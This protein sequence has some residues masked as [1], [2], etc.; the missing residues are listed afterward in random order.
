MYKNYTSLGASR[1]T[2]LKKQ[3][4][5]DVGTTSEANEK[6]KNSFSFLM[7]FVFAFIILVGLNANAQVSSY[8]FAQTTGTFTTLTGAVSGGGA[9]LATATSSAGGAAGLDD[10]IYSVTGFP[11]SYT[12]NGTAYTGCS[13]S[14]NG[15]ITFGGT[16]PGTTLYA[17]ITGA[18]AYNGAISAWGKDSDSFSAIGGRTGEIRWDVV[19]TSPNREIVIQWKDFRP[20]F[21][22]STT[23]VYGFSYQIRLQENG[24][25]AVIAYGP[26]S[27]A[28]GTTAVSGSTT[29]G[30]QV[31]LRGTSATDFNNRTNAATVLFTASTAGATNTTSI[32]QAFNTS[33]ATPGMPSNG[34]IYTYSPPTLC[35]GTP[36][37]GTIPATAGA[38]IGASTTLAVSGFTT[39]VTGITFQWL[40]SSDNIT[41]TNVVGG[42]GATTATY[43]TAAISATKYYQCKV[44]C[45]NG[46]GNATTNS[47]TVNAVNC[48]FDV[49]KTANTY[50]SISGTGTSLTGTWRN[51]VNTDDNLSASQPI[52]FAF[53]YKGNSYSTFSA[54]TNGFLTF[55]TGTAATGSGTGAYGYQNTAFTTSGGTG[56]ILTIAPFYEDLVAPG[57]PGTAAG[58]NAAIKYQLTGTAPNRVATIEWIG[59]ETFGN[60]GPNLNFQVKLYETTGAVEI[61]YGTMELFNGTFNFSYT[62][63][64][65]INGA[66]MGATPTVAE[67][68]TQQVANVQN[69]SNLAANALTGLQ[70]CNVKYVFT[71][72][73]YSGAASTPTITNDESAGAIALT[74]NSSPC[75]ALCGTYYR[76]AGAT[77]SAGIGVCTATTAGTPDD[78]VWFKFDATA[79]NTTIT[80]R[81]A[82][83]YDV[84][85]QLLD[86][87]L[88]PIS[89]ANGTLT[90]LTESLNPT[91]L[92]IGA[93]YYVRV[94]HSGAGNGTTPEISICVNGFTPPPAN[95]DVCGAINLTSAGTCTATSGS[96]LNSTP[97]VQAVCA[98]TADDDVWYKFTAL[99]SA[100][101]VTVQSGAGFNAHVQ[102]F[103]SSDNL[104]SGTLTSLACVNVTSTA[105]VETYT[106]SG[107]TAGN[108]YFVRVYH[109]ASGTGTGAFTICVTASTPAC[110]A[111]PTAP[112]NAGTACSGTSV[113]LSWP[114]ASGATS[115]DLVIDGGSVINQ[116]ALTYDAG[117]L[118]LGAHTWSVTPRNIV[119]TPSGCASWTF[120][121]LAAPVA[122]TASGPAT[123]FTA[124]AGSYSETG[125]GGTFQ[126]KSATVSGGPY[127]NIT[128]A[129]TNPASISFATPGTYYVVLVRTVSGCTV[130]TST[131]VTT[132]V[133]VRGDSPCAPIALVVGSNG[134]YS[135]AGATGDVGEVVPPLT[136]CNVQ[137]GWCPTSNYNSR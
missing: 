112:T 120:T 83:G 32:T 102:V 38:C 5:S 66:T 88:T 118:A 100:D 75:V 114:A 9:I 134:P 70:D 99:T 47:C 3:S 23:S 86:A 41:F 45:S 49:A 42:T 125:T 6:K 133:S 91:T 101:V 82:G 136:T 84:V 62:Y 61:V 96:T 69:F 98:G 92:T 93:T 33:V 11:F 8:T 122:G 31:G 79:V 19:G 10:V 89:C 56:S 59:M 73:A 65:G 121:V 54:S 55:N 64:M 29:T 27:F 63:T 104:C 129:T 77:A 85:L 97:S 72:A 30:P 109:S 128:G 115:Y 40:E 58:L 116:T 13:V 130:A 51:A 17:P 68:Q 103:S 53:S 14:T 131:E 2:W 111:N 46:G 110:I 87:S 81:G 44:T 25:K 12:F 18:T 124:E 74:V 1:D 15:F 20:A 108:T 126:W 16:A 60:A 90:G 107:L 52:G 95:D 106:G 80:V 117:V 43:T 26:G 34:L 67:L 39:G 132:V 57:N 7:Q 127:T 22:T 137:T 123:L 35:S 48:S 37:A 71:P 28:I 36:T 78:D 50:A 113:L 21:S 94:Y 119:G 105:G 76:T 24:N 135:N 4:D